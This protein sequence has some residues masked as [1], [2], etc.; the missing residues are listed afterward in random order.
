MEFGD[1]SHCNVKVKQE[2]MRLPVQIR[3]AGRDGI[4]VSIDQELFGI[5]GERGW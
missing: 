1:G 4:A 2:C 5:P 3:R